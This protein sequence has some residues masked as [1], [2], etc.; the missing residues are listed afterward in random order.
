VRSAGLLQARNKHTLSLF[1]TQAH[2]VSVCNSDL[3]VN[4]N[5]W[6]LGRT[7]IGGSC[8]VVAWPSAATGRHNKVMCLPC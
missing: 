8:L 7:M 5:V 3:Y 1:C 4:N 2:G 6:T